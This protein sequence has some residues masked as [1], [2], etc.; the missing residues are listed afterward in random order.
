MK[1]YK[2]RKT[3]HNTIR[4]EEIIMNKKWIIGLII[5]ILLG[6]ICGIATYIFI[7]FDSEKIKGTNITVETE[8][9]AENKETFNNLNVTSIETSTSEDLLSPNAIIIQK[10]YFKACDHL[11]REVQ[12]IADDL[13][14]G[15]REDILEKYPDWD[16]EEYTPTEVILYKEDSGNCGEH[17]MVKNHYG[18]I[19]IYTINE[20][21][22]EVFSEDTE[23]STKYLPEADVELLNEG[24][25]I[26]GKT[27]LIEFLE[28]FE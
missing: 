18:V 9:L 2:N 7:N 4:K 15:T 25:K 8:V 5:A 12:D 21:E 22:E 28:D 26:I 13:I 14:N 1:V 6:I 16:I 23:I 24:V 27:N 3:Y 17:Y 10:E 19:G 11:R 20:N